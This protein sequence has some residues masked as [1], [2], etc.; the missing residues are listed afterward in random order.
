MFDPAR[1]HDRIEESRERIEIS[2]SFQRARPRADPHQHRRQ[3]LLQA[4]RLQYP[5]LLH[6][7]RGLPGRP[8]QGPRVG[9]RGASGRP[10]G[11]RPSPR[12]RPDRGGPLLRLPD[13]V[14]GRHLAVGREALETPAQI[15]A[16]EVPDPAESQGLR[17]PTAGSRSS[18]RS[19]SGVASISPPAGESAFIRR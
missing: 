19:S 13:R 10:D 3:L 4:V 1:Y 9:L 15:E 11:L 14:P 18:R 12:L 16:F 5:R 2:A 7:P 6:R 8:A 17:R